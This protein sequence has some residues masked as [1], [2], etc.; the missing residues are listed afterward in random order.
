MPLWSG[1][2]C[3]MPFSFKPLPFTPFSWRGRMLYAFFMERE[4]LYAIMEWREML[5]AFCMERVVVYALCMGGRMLYAII[6]PLETPYGLHEEFYSFGGVK[7]ML[8]VFCLIWED[9]KAQ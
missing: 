4:M 3:F 5:Y 8:K 1:E 2:R 6:P 7:L 9:S